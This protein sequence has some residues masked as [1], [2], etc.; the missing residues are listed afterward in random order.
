MSR[1]RKGPSSR[2]VWP[3]GV[4]TRTGSSGPRHHRRDPRATPIQEEAPDTGLEEP[5]HEPV[6]EPTS[7]P[8]STPEPA[9]TCGLAT[10]GPTALSERVAG[11]DDH[12]SQGVGSINPPPRPRGDRPGSPTR[13]MD[14]RGA[15][16]ERLATWEGTDE[17]SSGGLI[18][19]EDHSEPSLFPSPSSWRGAGT[20]RCVVTSDRSPVPTYIPD[21][22]QHRYA[23]EAR[24][25]VH[26]R[27]H[28]ARSATSAK[29]SRTRPFR[30]ALTALGAIGVVAAILG[31]VA[32]SWLVGVVMLLILAIPALLAVRVS[33]LASAEDPGTQR[34]P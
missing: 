9:G 24:R 23:G 30:I 16:D 12:R 6:E 3:N 32:S 25:R 27:P 22:L 18:C 5:P 31:L 4:W 7:P 14:R 1:W 20:G 10:A 28:P 21:E 29:V 33:S 34:R 15:E 13:T 11:C 8:I 19:G 17:G 26:A 2:P